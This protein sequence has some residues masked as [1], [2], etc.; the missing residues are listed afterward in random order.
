MHL[1][2]ISTERKEEWKD[3]QHIHWVQSVDETKDH[4]GADAVIDLEFA[5][6]PE[7]I[8][9]LQQCSEV[10]IVNSN[11]YTLLE[12]NAPF[13][14]I[15]GWPG[16]LNGGIEACAEAEQREKTEQ[17]FTSLNTKVEWLPD[18][19]GFVTPRIISMIINEAFFALAEGV[20][21]KEEIDIAMKLGTAYPY[22]PFEWAEKIGLE[23]IYQ[24]LQKLGKDQPR[25]A[26]AQLLEDSLGK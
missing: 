10:V 1:V 5:L 8:N 20:S 26:P 16:F 13:V 15:N 17:V 6:T 19:V 14:R 7:R 3:H 12:I 4:S 11:L 9:A 25:Y 22:G 21:T 24:L 18:Q 23:N 2:V